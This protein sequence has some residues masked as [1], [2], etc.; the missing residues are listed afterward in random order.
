MKACRAE[1]AF[2]ETGL[3][4][5]LAGVSQFNFSFI[6]HSNN[7]LKHRIIQKLIWDTI[8]TEIKSNVI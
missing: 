4:E 3:M 8:S 6:Q 2:M 5:T 1:S 7:I